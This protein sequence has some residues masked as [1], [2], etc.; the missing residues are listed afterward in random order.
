[1]E[2]PGAPSIVLDQEKTRQLERLE[3][4][5]LWMDRRFLDPLL[6]LLLPGG[7]DTLG[8][9]VGLYG[10]F[11]AVQIGVHPVVVTRML[12]NLAVDSLIG[13]IPLLGVVFDVFYRAHV[14]NVALI[15]ARA[16]HRAARPSD[17]LVVLGAAFLF[18][19]ALL[20]PILIAALVVYW[21]LKIPFGFH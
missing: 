17:W 11:V 19:L 4:I 3:T 21:L 16:F 12:I 14:R 15:K 5:A 13:S 20:L 7:G 9:L 2:K 8:S 18:L 6:G 10:V 1:M